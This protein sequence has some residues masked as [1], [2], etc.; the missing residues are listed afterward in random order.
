MDQIHTISP[1][2]AEK[3]LVREFPCTESSLQQ[4]A[5]KSFW[6]IGP[7]STQSSSD[8]NPREIKKKK[9]QVD[10]VTRDLCENFE[11]WVDAP[12]R[13][14]VEHPWKK[15][16]MTPCGQILGSRQSRDDAP[17]AT[18]PVCRNGEAPEDTGYCLNVTQNYMDLKGSERV[19]EGSTR[20]G[21]KRKVD[22]VD[23]LTAHAYSD[24]ANRH[25]RDKLNDFYLRSVLANE[26][27]AGIVPFNFM[28]SLRGQWTVPS[29]SPSAY[30]TPAKTMDLYGLQ[31]STAGGILKR[32]QSCHASKDPKTLKTHHSRSTNM[33]KLPKDMQGRW[34]SERYKSAQLKLIE[35]MHE[36][37]AQ[38][39]RPIRRPALRGEARKHIGDTG[40]LDHLLKHMT[41]TVVST[42]ERFRRRHNAEGAMEYWLEDASLMEIRKAAGVE[43]PSWIPPHGWKP[44]D[45]FRSGLW[46]ISRS[47]SSSEAA[48]MSQLKE[49]VEVLK[50]EMK[51]LFHKLKEL[52]H[53]E[54][55]RT[56]ETNDVGVKPY[57]TG[58]VVGLRTYD[59]SDKKIS[60]EQ[61]EQHEKTTTAAGSTTLEWQLADI[62]KEV[63]RMQSD[64][65]CILKLL[66]YQQHVRESSDGSP[67]IEGFDS[68]TPGLLLSAGE[69]V[70]SVTNMSETLFPASSSPGGHT[71]PEPIAREFA[72]VNSATSSSTDAAGPITQETYSIR[73]NQECQIK[74]D[75]S[76]VP[77]ICLRPREAATPVWLNLTTASS[78]HAAPANNSRWDDYTNPFHR[79]HPGVCASATNSRE[80]SPV[81]F[82]FAGVSRPLAKEC[83]VAAAMAG[84][85]GCMVQTKQHS[86]KGESLDHVTGAAMSTT[87][88]PEKCMIPL[89]FERAF[90]ACQALA[91][92]PGDNSSGQGPPLS[93][94]LSLTLGSQVKL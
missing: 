54:V 9:D 85:F 38:P 15:A 24:H 86:I 8:G 76:S 71:H 64:V 18:I 20:W 72:S 41:D 21:V 55:L 53:M 61:E 65:Q 29:P 16:R 52:K 93:L 43:D 56:E 69:E 84:M 7:T 27:E 94:S 5:L 92:T 26:N 40:L 49:T 23:G 36:R 47:M 30:P 31:A 33:L 10:Q 50:R 70:L 88:R 68:G 11:S 2:A 4:S 58:H 89:S 25:L 51:F 63:N 34:S 62:R 44:G 32:T 67:Q 80:G 87:G 28:Q 79:D 14:E 22:A 13:A 46:E 78:N 83:P 57:E 75:G 60:E 19:S 17:I 77:Q 1:E 74:M 12:I 59:D 73:E 91:L 82:N 35:I 37:K 6:F 39:G 3:V 48:E 42:G 66:G 90:G 45:K 81:H